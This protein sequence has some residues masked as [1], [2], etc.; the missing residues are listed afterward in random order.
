MI[1]KDILPDF[2]WVK[3]IIQRYIC[4]TVRIAT[5]TQSKEYTPVH[6]RLISEIRSFLILG[7][8]SLKDTSISG[9]VHLSLTASI[10]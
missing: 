3:F 5:S 8:M 6:N 9:I 1:L 4:L 7:H 10:G 2:S